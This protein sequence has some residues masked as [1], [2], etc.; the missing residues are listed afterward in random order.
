MS[1]NAIERV[2][3]L[4][5][6][7]SQAEGQLSSVAEG[8]GVAGDRRR[9]SYSEKVESLEQEVAR[10]SQQLDS[11]QSKLQETP[12]GYTPAT[13]GYETDAQHPTALS[14]N[15]RFSAPTLQQYESLNALTYG[16]K[17]LS[18]SQQARDLQDTLVVSRF[19]KPVEVIKA[20]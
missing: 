7:V 11:M 9:Y 5:R 17:P 2:A 12:G 20:L 16:A 3:S 8:A 19:N 1:Q 6:R 4:E 13:S 15:P 18:C 10:L 14:S